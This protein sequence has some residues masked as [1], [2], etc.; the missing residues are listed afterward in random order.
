[1]PPIPEPAANAADERVLYEAIQVL[2]TRQYTFFLTAVPNQA[3][4]RAR[5]DAVPATTDVGALNKAGYHS[6]SA[7]LYQLSP[8]MRALLLATSSGHAS[9]ATWVDGAWV[10]VVPIGAVSVDPPPLAAMRPHLGRYVRLGLL[11]SPAQLRTAPLAGLYAAA[12]VDGVP[13]LRRLPRDVPVDAVLPDGSTLLLHSVARA[14]L[15]LTEELL[16]RHADPNHCAA[17]TCPLQMAEERG[18]PAVLALLR[19]AAVSTAANGAAARTPDS[20]Q[21]D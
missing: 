15:K 6:V 20:S 10:S 4:A 17:G 18:N 7:R 1:V 3:T 19:A 21:P 14:D 16:R 12:R 2:G 9:P 13:A 5:H 11:P 8:T